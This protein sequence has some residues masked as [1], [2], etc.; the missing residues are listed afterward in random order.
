MNLN[1]SL[2]SKYLKKI[3]KIQCDINRL[4]HK[5]ETANKK[6][7]SRVRGKY[8]YYYNENDLDEFVKALEVKHKEL[9]NYKRFGHI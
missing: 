8:V 6:Y 3:N 4:E 2:K 5:I 1:K 7:Y 9:E